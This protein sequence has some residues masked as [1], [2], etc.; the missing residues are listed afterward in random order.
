MGKGFSASGHVLCELRENRG[1]EIDRGR[2]ITREC[3]DVMAT[4]TA[5]VRS[6]GCGEEA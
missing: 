6:R 3:V 1:I 5:T 2:T 4:P